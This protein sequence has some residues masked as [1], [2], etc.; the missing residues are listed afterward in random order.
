MSREFPRAALAFVED[1]EAQKEKLRDVAEKTRGLASEL[2]AQF[3]QV[4]TEITSEREINKHIVAALN[5]RI[6]DVATNVEE[7]R[8]LAAESNTKL[9]TVIKLLG[10]NGSGGHDV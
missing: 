4:K 10:T 6:D 7:V 8:K 5:I 1:F 3:H 2:G 9:D